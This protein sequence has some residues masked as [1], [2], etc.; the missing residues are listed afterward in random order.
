VQYNHDDSSS[1][2]PA[3]L[4]TVG[5]GTVSFDALVQL[6]EGAGV[7]R[8]VDV[9]S[10][11]GSRRHPQFGLHQLECSLPAEGIG[12]RWEPDLGGF[13]RLLPG[14]PN[15]GLRHPSFR[16]YADYMTSRSFE[17]ALAHLLDEARSRVTAIMCAETLW[18]RCHRRLIADAAELIYGAEVQHLDHRGQLLPHRLTEGVNLESGHPIY[19]GP[20]AGAPGAG[21]RVQGK[22]VD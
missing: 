3:R 10:A 17:R 9:R 6:L 13:R 7:E 14:S 19:L 8:V 18:W 2:R 15:V 12:Y 21:A 16:G 11:P 22:C 5:H 20:A 1:D 4:I